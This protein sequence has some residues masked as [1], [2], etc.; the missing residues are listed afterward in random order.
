MKS[1]L[2]SRLPRMRN[3]P[4]PTCTTCSRRP[5]TS[6]RRHDKRT[7]CRL[8]PAL[9]GPY[10]SGDQR[11]D[12]GTLSAARRPASRIPRAGYRDPK[13]GLACLPSRRI[14][15]P[16][17]DRSS[18]CR[19]NIARG[20]RS[21]FAGQMTLDD[22]AARSP[23][24][25]G[26]RPASLRGCQMCASPRLVYLFGITASMVSVVSSGRFGLA[27]P[28]RPRFGMSDRRPSSLR[29]ASLLPPQQPVTTFFPW[30]LR[31]HSSRKTRKSRPGCPLLRAGPFGVRVDRLRSVAS[32]RG[33]D[34]RGPR[35]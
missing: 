32:H 8:P 35:N 15:V 10:V 4:S 7:A 30:P 17:F 16:A 31:V 14:G 24:R 1:A 26:P 25:F 11:R 27:R 34:G 22:Q 13:L 20:L 33:R 21:H 12:P 23:P 3:A 29:A 6:R 28:R 9:A 18:L 2:S 19:A 5:Q